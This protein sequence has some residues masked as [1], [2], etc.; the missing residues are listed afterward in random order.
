[1]MGFVR[2]FAYGIV[3]GI[4]NIVPAISAGTMAVLL[5]LYDK[6]LFSVS[7][8]N[9]KR[10][11]SFLIPL[12]LGGL[13]GMFLFS[14]F[15][16]ELLSTYETRINCC[17]I[18]MIAGGIPMIFRRVRAESIRLHSILVFLAALVA[19]FALSL[20][21]GGLYANKSL[22]QILP[23]EILDVL[24]LFI[25]AAISAIA[26]ILPGTSG[27]FIMLL[28]GAYAISLEAFATLYFPV[29]FP[30]FAGVLA[31]S[32]MGIKFMKKMLRLHPHLLYCAILG[33]IIGSLFTIPSGLSLSKE[34]ALRIGLLLLFT[35]LS[36][37][38]SRNAK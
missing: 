6:I 13:W 21:G 4:A 10:N 23:L 11:L 30:V 22:A 24:W 32:F 18:G 14:K 12:G 15:M 1:M 34:G 17:F 8:A 37:V 2:D 19:M 3:L 25:V 31:G 5:N 27:S 9:F 26:M 28:L 29:L 16:T 33:L 7:K 38:F 20:A 35:V 36:Y